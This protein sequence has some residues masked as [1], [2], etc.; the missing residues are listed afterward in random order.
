MLSHI[1]FIARNGRARL[2]LGRKVSRLARV[3]SRAAKRLSCTQLL[4]PTQ[5]PKLSIRGFV[6]GLRHPPHVPL[7]KSCLLEST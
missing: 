4:C 1:L 7:S 2:G 5:L 3:F 6:G